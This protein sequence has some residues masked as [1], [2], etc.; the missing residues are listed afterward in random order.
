M[1]VRV[2]ALNPPVWDS[3]GA[4]SLIRGELKL[5]GIFLSINT[6]WT[7]QNSSGFCFQDISCGT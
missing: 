2:G 3:N 4:T 5:P 1:Q 7:I 6:T